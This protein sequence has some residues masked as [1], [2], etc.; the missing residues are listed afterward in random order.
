M[1]FFFL[2]IPYQRNRYASLQEKD[3]AVVSWIQNGYIRVISVTM[4]RGS[5]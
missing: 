5:G 3:K 1:Y 4:Y 2:S